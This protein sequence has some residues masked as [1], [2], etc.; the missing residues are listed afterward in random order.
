MAKQ[1]KKLFQISQPKSNKAVV[2][3]LIGGTQKSD[4][5]DDF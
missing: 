4:F 2:L 3:N 5:Y 1:R